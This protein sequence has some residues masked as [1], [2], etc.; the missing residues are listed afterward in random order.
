MKLEHW[1]LLGLVIYLLSNE[2][3]VTTIK[4]RM[5]SGTV[6]YVKPGTLA[7]SDPFSVTGG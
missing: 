7:D 2:E 3:V 5:T 4:E 6:P 1:M